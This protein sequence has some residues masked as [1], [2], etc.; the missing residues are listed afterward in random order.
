M[1][2]AYKQRHLFPNDYRGRAAR[3]IWYTSQLE[4]RLRNYILNISYGV[5]PL[6]EERYDRFFA[7]RYMNIWNDTKKEMVELIKDSNQVLTQPSISKVTKFYVYMILDFLNKKIADIEE[8]WK[9]LSQT[10]KKMW[11]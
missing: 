2:T 4:A 7:T 3:S 10:K 5:T 9:I 8:L 6:E 1:E 11:G